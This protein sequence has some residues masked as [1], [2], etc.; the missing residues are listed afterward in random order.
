MTSRAADAETAIR[1]GL[2]KAIGDAER[3]NAIGGGTA[4]LLRQISA[5]FPIGVLLSVLSNA[6]D[7]LS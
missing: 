7:V 2:E 6:S 1:Q 4:R 3:T 5:S